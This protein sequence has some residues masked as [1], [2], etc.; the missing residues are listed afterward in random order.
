MDPILIVDDEKDNL[1]A[2]QR[3]LRSSYAVTTALSPFE[4]LRLLQKN[5]FHVI[6]SDQRMPE[7]TGVELLEKAK[8]L[9]PGSTRV[10]L[11]GFTEIESVIDAINRGNIYRYIA[12]PWDPEDLKLTI[13]QANEAF[14]LR[15]EVEE[16]NLALEKSNKELTRALEDLKALDRTKA[17]FLSLVSHE[18]N[19]PLTVLSS[20]VQLLEQMKSALPSEIQKAV[21]SIGS[22]SQRFGEIISE[23]LTYVRLESG[24]ELK[25]SSFSFHKEVET[26][27]KKHEAEWKK[28]SLR[29]SVV[30]GGNTDVPCDMEKMRLAL[31]K[32]I[33]DTLSRTPDKA[34]LKIEM[35]RKDGEVLI[36]F[37]RPGAKLPESAFKPFETASSEMHHHKN[38]GLSLAIAKLIFEA[39]GGK[40]R[41]E[42]SDKSQK[43]IVNVPAPA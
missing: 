20:F 17:R 35:E 38:L 33:L 7:M 19:T 30:G 16:K 23:V 21:A 5:Q 28:R 24:S 12:K 18:L 11:T 27:L 41:D 8:K 43:L 22:A 25:L 10:L 2:L 31:E 4:A 15:R 32:L 26:L 29:V 9:S 39:H 14:L 3:L 13:R 36:S 1:E 42:S 34:E 40:I 37:T 6:I